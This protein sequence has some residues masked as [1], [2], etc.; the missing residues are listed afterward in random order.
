[1]DYR[2]EA[3]NMTSDESGADNE[4]YIITSG[5]ETNVSNAGS[6]QQHF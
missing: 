6:Q 2:E 4:K 3:L 1:M 5:N